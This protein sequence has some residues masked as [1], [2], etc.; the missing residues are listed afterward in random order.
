MVLALAL[1]VG[2]AA[3]ARPDGSAEAKA[4]FAATLKEAQ[5]GAAARYVDLAMLYL[6]GDGVERDVPQALAWLRKGVAGGDTDAMVELGNVYFD[7]ADGVK[8]DRR[9]AMKLYA[10]AA[11]LGDPNGMYNLGVAHEGGEGLPENPRLALSWYLKAAAAG[12]AR[13]YYS[14]GEAYLDGDGTRVDTAKGVAMLRKAIEMGSADAMNEMGRLHS[15][16]AGGVRLDHAE[17]LKLYSAAAANDLPAGMSNLGVVHH[18]GEGVPVN[19]TQAMHWFQLAADRG[20]LEAW[21]DLGVMC[22][23][24]Q[25]IKADDDLALLMYRKAAESKDA[26]LR[27]KAQKAINR[28]TGFDDDDAPVV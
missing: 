23:R 2:G 12:S 3:S 9:A 21:Y 4:T 18:N 17:A 8:I 25:G 22:E 5:G 13:G 1:S 7:G 19:Y 16:G 24:G 6:D 14:A 15:E 20:Y 27:Q 26:D 11:R 10:Q 28:L